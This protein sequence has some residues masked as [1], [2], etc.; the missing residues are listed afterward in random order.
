MRAFA[1]EPLG[2]PLL[3]SVGHN[4]SFNALVYT[5]L[6]IDGVFLCI[7]TRTCRISIYKIRIITEKYNVYLLAFIF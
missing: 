4:L 5:V 7:S 3:F 6:H 1:A 2:D